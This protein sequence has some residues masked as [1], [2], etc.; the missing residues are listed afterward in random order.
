MSK[1][2][3]AA[4]KQAEVGQSTQLH[5]TYFPSILSSFNTSNGPLRT[6]RTYFVARKK[7]ERDALLAQEEA[8]TSTKKSAP[9]AGSK[10]KDTKPLPQ[11][12]ILAGSFSTNDPLGLRKGV[13]EDGEEVKVTELSAMGVEDMLEALEVVNQKTDKD[14][15]G[16]KVSFRG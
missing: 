9:K 1:G 16:A 15:L 8:T 12:G 13:G 5:R 11:G 10:K 7:A 3:A 6:A 14:T 2:E 4:A